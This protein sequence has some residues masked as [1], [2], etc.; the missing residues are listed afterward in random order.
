MKPDSTKKKL[1]ASIAGTV[2]STG[3]RVPLEWWITTISAAIR[4]RLV[5][6]FSLEPELL[7]GS[8]LVI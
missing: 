2:I 7:T 6:A 5:S 4:R 1:T 3:S 8:D